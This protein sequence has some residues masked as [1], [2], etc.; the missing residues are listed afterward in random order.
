MA[1]FSR[2]YTYIE[3]A[4]KTPKTKAYTMLI[5]SL[6]AI[7]FF[8]IFA[9]R[10]TAITILSLQKEIRQAKEVDTKLAE[11]IELLR[12]AEETLDRIRPKKYLVVQALPP[13]PYVAQ[14][15]RTIEAR[16]LKNNVTLGAIQV[17]SV[18]LAGEEIK[19]PATQSAEPSIPVGTEDIVLTGNPA[20]E[21]KF[22]FTLTGEE[23]A[24]AGFLHDL[25]TARRLMV[26]DTIRFASNERS[27]GYNAEVNV[28]AYY[29]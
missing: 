23:A 18:T 1:Q 19:G 25:A 14:L 27:G 29:Q 10:P 2:Y 17:R 4:F 16:A 24:I 21:I 22:S 20:N 7:A 28:T 12:T 5:F 6:F 8:G 9:I 15:I 3:P 13:N 11:K 26:M